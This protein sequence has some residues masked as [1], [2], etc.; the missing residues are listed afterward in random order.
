MVF[1]VPG[2][3]FKFSGR[4]TFSLEGFQQRNQIA[5]ES[6][7]EGRNNLSVVPSSCFFIKS[8]SSILEL[9]IGTGY[10]FCIFNS[11]SIEPNGNHP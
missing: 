3:F 8:F 2:I 7:S 5:L 11:V 6:V 4:F 9:K 1:F 10:Y